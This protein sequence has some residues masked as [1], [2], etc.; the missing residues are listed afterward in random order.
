L[1]HFLNEELNKIK[2]EKCVG[3]LGHSWCCWKALGE[4]DLIGFISQFS[5]LSCGKTL[6]L[7]GFLLLDIFLKIAKIGF[8]RKI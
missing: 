8:G 2:T 7:S 1:N 5:E 4:S 6:F 3:I